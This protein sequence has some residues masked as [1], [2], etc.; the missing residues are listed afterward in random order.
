MTTSIR[1][2]IKLYIREQALVG[3]LLRDRNVLGNTATIHVMGCG[4][5]HSTVILGAA[6]QKSPT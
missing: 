3:G 1:F 5:P 2:R 6:A 4:I